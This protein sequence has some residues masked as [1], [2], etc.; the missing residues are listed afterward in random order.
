MEE[1]GRDESEA[2]GRAEGGTGGKKKDFD[3]EVEE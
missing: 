3:E 2:E 1:K